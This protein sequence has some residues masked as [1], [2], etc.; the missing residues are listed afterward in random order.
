MKTKKITLLLMLTVISLLTIF[1]VVLM[2]DAVLASTDTECQL[3]QNLN[4]WEKTSQGMIDNTQS[5]SDARLSREIL[6]PMKAM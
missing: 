1:L 2:D 6:H 3:L 5:S 4:L